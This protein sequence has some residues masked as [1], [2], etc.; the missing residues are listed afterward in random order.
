[1]GVGWVGQ[2]EVFD[3]WHEMLAAGH[4]R[5]WQLGL[6]E[7]Q[8]VVQGGGESQDG[9][10]MQQDLAVA[11]QLAG[12]GGP[13]A[14][15][16]LLRVVPPQVWGKRRVLVGRNAFNCRRKLRLGFHNCPGLCKGSVQVNN[17]TNIIVQ[18][19]QEEQVGFA[20]G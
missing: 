15:L 1:M 13:V 3:V 7:S 19:Q 18:P 12:R 8:W 9:D 14:L 2:V 17:D 4:A 5:W 11:E 10:A 16:V 6:G 20:L